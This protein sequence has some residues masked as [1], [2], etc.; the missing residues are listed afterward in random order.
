MSR[1]TL[2]LNRFS[3]GKKASSEGVRQWLTTLER[4]QQFK[5]FR[6]SRAQWLDTGKTERS[7]YLIERRLLFPS[8]V[9]MEEAMGKYLFSRRFRNG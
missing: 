6:R 2:P 5:A 7:N 4:S 1:W 8:R 9:V 3:A